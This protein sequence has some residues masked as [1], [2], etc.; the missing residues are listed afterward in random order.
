[1]K[2]N[3][4]TL[5]L[6]GSGG[7]GVITTGDFITRAASS[8]GIYCLTQMSYGPQI[9]G[10]ESSIRVRMSHKQ[11][12]SRG[13]FVDSLLVFSW[14]DYKRFTDEVELR[15]GA[16]VLYE[17]ADKESP[18]DFL[19]ADIELRLQAVPFK[20]IA[21]E[22]VGVP[23]TKNMVALGVLAEIHGFN[24][25][26]LKQAIMDKYGKKRPEAAAKNIEA[27]DA[28]KAWAQEH[29][30]KEER[31]QLEPNGGERLLVMN[32]DEA[33][34]Y[35]ALQA[36][37]RYY[38]GYPIT[39]ATPILHWLQQELPRFGGT[40]IQ[41]EDEI[42]AI[43]QCVGASWAGVKAMT[44]SSGPGIALMMEAMGL[45]GM[46]EIPLTIVN[47]QRVG[48]STGIPSKPE[49][50]D[51]LQALGMHGDVPHA[52]FAPADV[53]DCFQVAMEA[54]ACSERYQMPV[55]ILSDQFIGERFESLRGDRF[56]ERVKQVER[57]LP[58]LSPERKYQRY[59]FSE[60]GV[61]P[62]AVPGLEGGQYITSGLE[63]D[64]SGAPTSSSEYHQLMSDKRAAKLKGVAEDFD[65]ARV[66]GNKDAEFGIICW[67]SLKGAVREAIM[68]A[69]DEG[70]KVAAY[71]P[72]LLYPVP[73][74]SLSEFLKGKRKVMVL[75]LS[76]GAQFYHYLKGY[77]TDLPEEFLSHC[78]AGGHL[79]SIEEVLKLIRTH[80]VSE[81]VA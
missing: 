33:L 2:I 54:V 6:A 10:G 63:H 30:P 57:D 24:Q 66:Y 80:S 27:F 47:V 4:L 7:D 9:R 59:A 41:A 20:K 49:Q 36:G 77:A 56:L 50:A 70:L 58:E 64:E 23:L 44:A 79:F 71:V 48:P 35:G 13:D 34:A 60:S 76:H 5:T 38:A 65:F 16:L 31:L 68:R 55:I 19:P 29:G 75:E 17:E 14:K 74:R 39:P 26:R 11:A 8:D 37:V 46:A 73:Q 45:A 28:G 69:Q 78:R 62:M 12:Q 18:A 51:L 40:V 1:M 25:E 21:Q 53:E 61:S 32:G 42:S 52:I 43:T 67:G 81:L 3:D 15:P 72:Q 22:D